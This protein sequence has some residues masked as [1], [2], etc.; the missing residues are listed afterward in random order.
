MRKQQ[1]QDKQKSQKDGG[2]GENKTSMK[3]MKSRG[4]ALES[5]QASS[6]PTS[7]SQVENGKS[8]HK[9]NQSQDDF[10]SNKKKFK[11]N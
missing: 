7:S 4:K 9:R 8:S 11:K 10:K 2:D 6:K 5:A 3:Y 1:Q